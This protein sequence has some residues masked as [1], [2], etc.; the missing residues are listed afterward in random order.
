LKKDKELEEGKMSTTKSSDGYNKPRNGRQKKLPNATN[1]S[2]SSGTS[3]ISKTSFACRT[4]TP[5]SLQK[6]SK[7]RSRAQITS[8]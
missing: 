5:S 4:F 1:P 3:S 7:K 8:N 2:V 6:G